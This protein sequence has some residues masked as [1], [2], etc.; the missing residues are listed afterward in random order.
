[1]AIHVV[2][3]AYMTVTV[4]VSICVIMKDLQPKENV[5][6]CNAEGSDRNRGRAVAL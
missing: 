5:V 4:Y 3:V 2:T 6:N 1:M